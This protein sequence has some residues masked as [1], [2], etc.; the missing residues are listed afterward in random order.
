MSTHFISEENFVRLLDHLQE[1]SRVY[2]AQ[3]VE[4][5]ETMVFRLRE[6]GEP[7]AYTGFRATQSLKP[8]L[9]AAK[10]K[11]AEYPL[12]LGCETLPE[13]VPLTVVGAAACDLAALRTL[14]AVFMSEDVSDIFYAERRAKTL[15][16][17]ME[18]TEP[19]DTCCCTL[20]GNKPYAEDGFDLNLAKAEGGFVVKTGSDKGQK[21]VDDSNILFSNATEGMLAA[22]ESARDAA[23]RKV[24]EINRDV[25][26]SR[27]RQEVLKR[28]PE[29][30]EWY[31]HVRTCVECA[32]CLF[33]CPTC[34]CFLLHDRQGDR[35]FE[36]TKVWDGCIYAGYSRMAGGGT[37]RP[38]VVERFRHRF[39]HKYDQILERYGIEGCSGCGR[40]IEACPG[41]ID[42]RKVFK[43][44]ESMGSSSKVEQGASA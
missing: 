7:F 15:I 8:F 25:E 26:L 29:N 42:F 18:C 22:R 9:F 21:V 12:P 10:E 41:L 36:R 6:E 17:S 11:V 33:S 2:V 35:A 13:T 27:S 34:H 3:P 38:L 30:R 5:S 31:P 23:T 37:P 20:L 1:Q 24:Q 16:I 39:V 32:A 43:A 14:D 19:R 40:C 44:L 4:E 28:A